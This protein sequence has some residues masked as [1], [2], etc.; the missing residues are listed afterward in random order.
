MTDKPPD[1]LKNYLVSADTSFC[2]KKP[3]SNPQAI[4]RVLWYQ[5]PLPEATEVSEKSCR[6]DLFIPGMIHLP[7]IPSDKIIYSDSKLPIMPFFP[8]VL[9]KIQAW[10]AHMA[11]T[12]PW[13]TIKQENDISDINDLLAVAATAGQNLGNQIWL[14]Q[15][16]LAE[17]I[18]GVQEYV[19]S[20]PETARGWRDLGFLKDPTP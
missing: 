6:V 12:K 2:W 7:Q 19:E 9:H 3:I 15:W 18:E 14:E 8:V 16:F 4:Y 5:F 13:V 1:E 11:S 20:H 17:A 10:K